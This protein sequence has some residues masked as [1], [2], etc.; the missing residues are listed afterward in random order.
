MSRRRWNLETIQQI[1]DGEQPFIQFGY[2]PPTIK[3]KEGEKWTDSKGIK[4]ILKK[5][6]KIRINAQ[7]DLIRELVKRKCSK[8]G[9]DVGCWGTKLDEKI[10]A[11]TGMCLD[12]EQALHTVMMIEGTLDNHVAKTQLRNKI[13]TAKEF[14]R[15]VIESID[16]LK[17]DNSKIEMVHADG[18][19]TTF[20][21]SQNERLLK[22]CESDLERVD[23]LLIELEEES[24]K[25]K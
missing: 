6:I 10:Y 9:F 12:C 8:C 16:F 1:I 14:K 18:S 17:K 20:V 21:G 24:K 11:K 2:H 22:E 15:N 3:R 13:S 7:A 5:G 4:W 23:K 19:M 25:Y